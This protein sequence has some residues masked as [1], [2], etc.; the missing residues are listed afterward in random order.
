MLSLILLIISGA[1]FA[2]F[3]TQNTHKT[4]I[5][6]A[7]YTISGVPVY[8]MVLGALL[9][10]ILISWIIS[11]FG[12]VSSSLTIRGK[13][14]KINESKKEI[15]NLEKRIRDLELENERLKGKA[16]SSPTV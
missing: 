14:S 9:L 1:L 12:F 15:G 6:L 8:V 7:Y 10:G 3:A 2:F 4:D 5:T 13:N 11:F 16:E